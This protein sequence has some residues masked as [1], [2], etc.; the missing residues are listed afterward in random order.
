MPVSVRYK[1]DPN[2]EC[3]IRPAPL[4]STSTSVL[5]NAD[6]EF[7]KTYNITLTGTLIADHGFPLARDSRTDALFPYFGPNNTQ[8][9]AVGNAGPYNT[10][11]TAQSHAFEPGVVDN[12]PNQQYVPLTSSVDALLFKQKVLRALFSQ[13][14]QR[15]E[16]SPIHTDEPSIVC[17]PRL[18]D[19]QFDENALTDICSYTVSLEADVLYD[20][21]LEIDLDGNP[22]RKEG[23]SFNDI[24]AESGRFIESFDESWNLEVD[25]AMSESPQLVKSYRITR[26]LSAV[27]K[28]SYGPTDLINGIK[29]NNKLQAWEQARDFVQFKLSN[30]PVSSGYPNVMGRIGNGLLNLVNV[31]EGFNHTRT[32]NISISNGSYEISE[33]WLL[34]SGTAYEN[35]ESSLSA[36]IDNSF[37]SVA[38]NGTITG[39]SSI[40][41]SGAIYG[42]SDLS[43]EKTPY[44]NALNK[45]YN[46]SNSGSFGI[47]CDIYKRANNLV[48]V[49][50]NAQ[51][52]SISISNNEF[53]GTI[54]YALDFDNRPTNIFS[55]V[56]SENISISDTYPGDVFSVI[57]VMGRKTGPILRYGGSRTEYQRSLDI[58]MVLDYNSIPYGSGRSSLLLKKPSV[59]E[60]T[61]SQLI[62]LVKELGPEKEPGVIRYF[63]APPVEN[64]EPKNGIYSLNINWTYERNI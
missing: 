15:I 36:S 17:F 1:N 37:I 13:D 40:S 4:V 20:N 46:I 10:F 27:G 22:L 49:E 30:E 47:G 58:S 6:G 50:L 18:V 2:Q 5:R 60:P 8:V 33:T 12:R 64:W 39:L 16:I 24:I 31:Y 38:I 43:N 52:K 56:I 42:G 51:P 3:I 29:S 44:Q 48:A 55:G 9:A 11:D 23:Q 61:R 21:N 14:G 62:Q 7:G 25:D 26:N 45:Y 63:I 59:A 57:P 53:D 54:T 19:I 41:P 32:E 28:N 34:S 35:F